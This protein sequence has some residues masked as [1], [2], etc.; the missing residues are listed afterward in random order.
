MDIMISYSIGR[1]VHLVGRSRSMDFIVSY[2]V[3]RDISISYPLSRTIK[4]NGM[5]NQL[6]SRSWYLDIMS[7]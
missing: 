6:L 7:I 2:S 1:D 5:H 4:V 3:G